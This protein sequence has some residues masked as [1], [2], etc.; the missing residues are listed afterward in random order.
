VHRGGV[1]LEE[2]TVEQSG[3]QRRL[4]PGRSSR[5]RKPVDTGSNGLREG[6]A[7]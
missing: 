4:V 7:A 3:G 1:K 5:S 6:V 2:V